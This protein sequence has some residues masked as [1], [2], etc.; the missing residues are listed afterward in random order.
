MPA[1]SAGV[2]AYIAFHRSALCAAP[3]SFYG[4][5][6]VLESLGAEGA[7]EAAKRLCARSHIPGIDHAVRFLTGH[8]A[9]DIGHM[10]ELA[11]QLA[12]IGAPADCHAILCSAYVTAALYPQFF[13]PVPSEAPSLVELHQSGLSARA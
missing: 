13:W 3:L 1:P 7:E 10:D 9:A 2:A 11:R 12:C 5:A 4:S 8:G 6:W